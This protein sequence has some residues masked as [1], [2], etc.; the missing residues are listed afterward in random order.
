MHRL[1][2]SDPA[3]RVFGRMLRRQ[4]QAAGDTVFLLND[5][6]RITYAE[7]D[8]LTDRLAGGLA[9][10]G[11]GKGDRV[12]IFMGNRPEMVLL[13]LAV[14]KL[15]AVWVPICTDYKGAWLAETLQRSRVALLLTDAERV[16]R[17]EE[18]RGELA[19][20]GL[21]V[22]G[23]DSGHTWDTLLEA[24][25]LETDF[26]DQSVG[27][28]CAVLWT[29]GTTGRSKGVMQSYEC[30]I[31][32]IT[33]GAAAPYETRE[34]DVVYCTLPLYHS[35]AWITCVLRAFIEGIT[36]VIE[37]RFSVTSFWDRV[38]ELG[39]T[40]T[41]LLGAMGVF[42]WN[43]PERDDDA[44]SSLRVAQIV[45]M[46][47]QLWEAFEA[48]FG[49]KLIRSGLGMS[50]ALAVMT[51]LEDRDDVPTYALGFPLDDSDVRLCDDDG[52]VVEEGA[53]GEICI[54]TDD[55]HAL[56][57]GYFDDPEAT[58]AAYRDGY[59][60]TGDLARQD[61]ETGAYFYV[62]RKKDV[63]RF[64]GRN[65]STLEVE[66]VAR[67]HPK[68]AD[69]A[70]FGVQSSEVESE[71][72]LKLNVVPEAGAELA[73]EELCRF[74]NENAPYYFVPRYVELV[75]ALPYTPTNKVQKFALR[76][77]GVTPSTWDRKAAGFEVTR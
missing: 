15:G 9:E 74:I 19:E 22:L 14:N 6:T 16:G 43:A 59:F 37:P 77:A 53:P 39:V 48:R 2:L 21:V 11:V 3:D 32:A 50:E 46:P 42:L 65:I 40:Q 58:A 17:I 67:R 36:V 24:P 64:A 7:A 57:S 1:D 55:P 41:F 70:A 71:H 73:P 44:D 18:V 20:T 56:F 68:V 34:G 47:P 12:A 63:V 30:W 66:S 27:D 49:V 31:R 51:Q 10:L 33:K 60:L 28:T 72:E 23:G 25:P 76:E 13:A 38:R 35:G 52:H 61:P 75:E 54:K 69:V 45:P 62:D 5:D 29:S 26:A 8:A 4:A